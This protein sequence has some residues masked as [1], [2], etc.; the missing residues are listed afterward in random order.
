MI[1]SHRHRFIFIKTFKTAGTSLEVFLSGVCGPDDVVTPI[2]PA[3]EPHRPRNHVGF[4][5]HM[6]AAA[7]RERVGPAVWDAYYK[8]CVERCPWD[9]T[10]SFYH[11]LNHRV[12]GTLRF[13][14][15]LAGTDFPHNAPLYTEPG[16]PTKVIVD[17]VVRYERLLPELTEVFARLGIP[18]AGTL[19]VN[20]KGE[21][22]TDRRPPGEVYTP[23][24]ARRVGEVFAVERALHGYQL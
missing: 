3:V 13:D 14:T 10:L 12:G 21:Y 15:F 23:D 11:M 9:K 17:R 19:G 1:V 6:P 22:R 8:F 4:Y 5:N 2:S 16:D 7:V 24:Q 20:A 18:F